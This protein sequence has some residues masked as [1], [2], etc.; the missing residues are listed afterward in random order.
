M[1]ERIRRIKFTIET[2]EFRVVRL[3]HSGRFAFCE[4]CGGIVASLE[5][6]EA[7]MI[8][9]MSVTELYAAIDQGLFHLVGRSLGNLLV[10]GHSLIRG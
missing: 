9:G 6:E 5:P 3:A 4:H 1:A 8:A 10:C 7:A 2:H